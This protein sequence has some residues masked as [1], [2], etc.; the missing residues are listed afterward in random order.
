MER[1]HDT[2][3]H[4][5][6]NFAWYHPHV[7]IHEAM[8]VDILHQLMKGIVMYMIEWVKEV[9]DNCIVRARKR[10]GTKRRINESAR[11]IQLDHRFRAV[12]PFL[13]LKLFRKFTDVKRWTSV[14]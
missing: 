7:N 1:S 13:T 10:K 12:P 5:V 4:D 3:V 2:W 6:N 11:A 14:E 9:I 8:M